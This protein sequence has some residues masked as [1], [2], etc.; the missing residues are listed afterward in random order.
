[1]EKQIQTTFGEL[2]ASAPALGR[3]L[4]IKQPQ[5][6]VY[7]VAKLVKLVQSEL[8]HFE[9][10]REALV[11]E[12][13]TDRDPTPEEVTKR[14]ESPVTEITP[15]NMP[16]F[17]AAFRELCAVEVELPWRQLKFADL[18]GFDVSAADVLAMEP[19]LSF[20]ESLSDDAA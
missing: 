18:S 10:K 8:T 9:E 16:K 1:M 17:L 5:K 14:G 2:S 7:H 13:G 3:L 6:V 19:L 11:K 12:F 4:E 15:E 20:E